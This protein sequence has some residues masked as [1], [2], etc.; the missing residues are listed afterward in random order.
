MDRL[1]IQNI[2][3]ITRVGMMNDRFR[4]PAICD[5]L[6]VPRHGLNGGE[7]KRDHGSIFTYLA[8]PDFWAKVQIARGK[9]QG[10]R[11]RHQFVIR[12]TRVMV[13]TN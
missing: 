4:I 11:H 5:L 12:E 9:Y 13:F 7:P 8:Q 10:F 3:S 1:P 2:R 6:Q